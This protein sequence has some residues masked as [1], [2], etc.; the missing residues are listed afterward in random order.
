MSKD[1]P[2]TSVQ[3]Y[4]ILPIT[5]PAIPSY[6]HP[7]THYL[8]IRPHSPKLPDPDS[9]RSL[10]LVNIPVTT[11]ETTLRHLFSTQLDAGR[12]ERVD[13]QDAPSSKRS[14]ITLP[15]GSGTGTGV[16]TGSNKSRSK[17]RKRAGASELE[18]ELENIELPTTWDRELHTSGAHAVVVFVDR[19]SME[20]SWKAVRKAAK[21][22]KGIVWEEGISQKLPPLGVERYKT[23]QRLRYPARNELMGVVNQYMSLFNTLEETKRIEEN[24]K[25]QMVD[26]DGFIMVGK[27]GRSAPAKE[28]EATEAKERA[29]KKN[30]GLEDFYR[31][32]LREKRKASQG[33]LMHRFQDDRRRVAEMRRRRLSGRE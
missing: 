21:A 22:R 8:Y 11:T 9:S 19:A 25:R 12:V 10:F 4:S 33:E 2:L 6:P 20:A 14:R 5:F 30:K 26:E 28:Q 7:T 31:F 16:Q 29:E 32:Q 18:T 23:H 27:G 15:N 1:K 13:F 3:D 24:K 17:K